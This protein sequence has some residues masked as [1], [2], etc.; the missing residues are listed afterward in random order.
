VRVHL[1]ESKAAVRLETGFG[2]ISKV[3]EERDQVGLRSVGS[4]VANIARG[5]PLRSLRNNHVVALDAVGREM[6]VTEGG[7]WRHSHGG[8]GL[9]LGNGRLALLVG[10]VAADGTRSKPFAVHGAEGALSI[11]TIP[12]R[13]E[14]VSTRPASLHVPHDTSFRH[15]AECGEGLEEHLIVDLVGQVANEDVVVVRSVLLGGVV[16]L[17]S[18]VDANFLSESDLLAQQVPMPALTL[19]W[20]RRPLSV[21]M[22]R[23]AAPG[24]SYSTNP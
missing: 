21:A 18:P 5:L 4:Q 24:S 22:P 12:E 13:D 6:V 23:S 1:D 10:P 20:M 9:L 8:H 11:S 19:L 17:V 14:S 2:D 16:G 3:L 7:R 15:G